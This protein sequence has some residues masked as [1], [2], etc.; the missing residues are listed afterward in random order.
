MS[1]E[2]LSL[3]GRVVIVGAG[4]AGLMTALELAPRPVV[5]LSKGPLGAESSTLWAQGGLAA[6]MG[7][8]DSP[9]LHAADTL[10]AGDGLC[11]AAIVDRVHPR[12]A[13]RDLEARAARRALRPRRRR[14]LCARA[15]GRACPS[16]H[17][18]C[19]RRRRGTRIDARAHRRRAGDAFDRHPRRLRGAPPDRRRQ[20]RLRPPRRRTGGA[21]AVARPTGS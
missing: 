17:R 8:G 12:R 5:V 14:R 19:G 6:A 4:I 13:R 2:I 10:A 9:A 15:R 21:G 20:R 16:A 11:D 1:A 3:R 18:A 7:A